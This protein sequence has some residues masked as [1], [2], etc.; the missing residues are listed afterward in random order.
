M[1]QEFI[2][3]A[4]ESISKGAYFSNFYGGA[5]IRSKDI[6]LVRQRLQTR[7]QE[8]NL[9]GELKWSKVTEQYLDKYQSMMAI[10]FALVHQGAI[11]L[12]IMFTQNML[13]PVGLSD[14]QQ[15]Y[16]YY[17]LYYQFIKHAFGL[18]YANPDR[19]PIY[20]R[21][22]LDNLPDTKEKNAQFKAY[23][24]GLQH[25]TNFR[26][27]NIKTRQD[28]IAEVVSH[29]H[30]ILQ[31]LDVVL[32]AMQFRL[33][34]KHKMKPLGERQRGKKTIAK[35]KL[36]K[37]IREQ[38]LHLYPGFNVGISTGLQ[39]N[40]SNLWHHAYRHWLFIPSEFERDESKKK[41]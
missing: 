23:L 28:Q 14:Y 40:R 30:A 21:I 39:G 38:I 19:H 25:T 16:T 37:Y 6:E 13:V 2:I 33:N 4:D 27:A 41:R 17:L 32:G 24:A 1:A 31:C 15:E 29:D 3:Y 12:R 36:Y 10:F 22:Y 20:L 5:L 7:K 9:F 8:L 34:D 35:E 11:K 26:E 18:R